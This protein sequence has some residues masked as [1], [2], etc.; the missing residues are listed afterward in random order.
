M[1]EPALNQILVDVGKSA[2]LS[3]GRGQDNAGGGCIEQCIEA[4]DTRWIE[5]LPIL[6]AP[7]AF[8]RTSHLSQKTLRIENA[9][10]IKKTDLHLKASGSSRYSARQPSHM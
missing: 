6:L 8:L 3:P 5:K 2:D 4:C 10:D 9:V 7:R 1:R